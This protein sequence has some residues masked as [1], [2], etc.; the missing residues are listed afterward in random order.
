MKIFLKNFFI[1]SLLYLVLPISAR[2]GILADTYLLTG[3]TP[4]VVSQAGN[5]SITVSGTVTGLAGASP[6]ISSIY[7]KTQ[8]VGGPAAVIQQE[9]FAPDTDGNFTQ[10]ITGLECGTTQRVWLYEAPSS[11]IHYDDGGSVGTG[12]LAYVDCGS[13]VQS[14][15]PGDVW[16]PD[17]AQ[18]TSIHGV[19]W[20]T[21]AVTDHSI[22]ISN[23]HLLP[24][25]PLGQKKFKIE[26]GHGQQGQP[27]ST[28]TFLGESPVFTRTA[29]YNFSFQINSL[30]PNTNYYF[31]LKEVT[32]DQNNN[33][34]DTN[35]FVYGYA[36]TN[37]ITSDSVHYTFPTDHSL[38]VYG[39]LSN[40][41][42]VALMNLPIKVQILDSADLNANVVDEVELT[43]GGTDLINGNGFFEYT[44]QNLTPATTYYIVV[45]QANSGTELT[46]LLEVT[47]PPAN[48]A[49]LMECQDTI[50]NDADGQI[51]YPADTGCESATDN[52]EYLAVLPNGLIACDGINC[53]F[54]TLIATIN[55]VIDFLIIFIAFPLV[56][57]VVAWAGFQLIISGGGAE[58]RTHAKSMIGKV[59][60]GLIIA[61][62]SWCIIKL[63]LI[64]LGYHGPLLSV[65][66]INQ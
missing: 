66:G 37:Q 13:L 15:N 57:I 43:T 22:T 25:P 16:A 1:L 30:T 45:K 49:G 53:D 23:A 40:N 36:L 9:S 10:N 20:G 46:Q 50:D 4:S 51:D 39:N 63:I 29:P 34:I 7:F 18:A 61:L 11:L 54:D 35:L 56:A 14:N 3:V 64:T 31:N 48:G 41:A 28:Y 24:F 42:G 65:F 21:V 58:Q 55:R 19:N 26:Y 2:A 44:F 6:S 60:I 32:T 62:L 27:N 8:K 38:H 5:G 12:F 52:S 33:T 47:M 59:L 17:S